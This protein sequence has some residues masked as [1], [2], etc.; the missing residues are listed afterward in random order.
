MLVTVGTF[1]LNSLTIVLSLVTML[2][3]FLFGF[4]N[5]DNVEKSLTRCRSDF[6]IMLSRDVAA[7]VENTISLL[8]M[9]F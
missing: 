3:L 6:A 4:V 2:L 7:T 5:V 1:R 8:S 9:I